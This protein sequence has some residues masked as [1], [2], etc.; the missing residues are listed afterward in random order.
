ME[1]MRVQKA[2]QAAGVPVLLLE[3]DYPGAGR[4]AQ[5]AQSKP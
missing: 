1:G 4:P 2:L 5:D 3:G